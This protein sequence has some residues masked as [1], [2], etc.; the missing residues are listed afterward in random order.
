MMKQNHKVVVITGASAGIGRATALE[1]ARQ[2]ASVGLI[3][4]DRNRLEEVVHRIHEAGGTGLV[5]VGDVADAAAMNRAADRVEEELGAIDVWINCAM[6]TIFSPFE[7]MSADEFRRVTEVTYLGTVHGTKAA[8][9]HMR[10]RNHGTIVQAGSALAYRSIPLQSA[11]CGAKFAI[12]GFTDAVRVELMHERS[13][14]HVTM[15]QLAAFNTPQFQWARS[16]LDAP[17][18]PVPPIFQPELAARAL[19]FA[20]TH[21]RREWWVGF[22]AAKAIIGTRLF[23]GF[24]DRKV[25]RMAWSGQ[26]DTTADRAVTVG[27]DNLFTTVPGDFGS[28]GRFDAHSRKVSWQWLYSRHRRLVWIVFIVVVAAAVVVTRLSM[29]NGPG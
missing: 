24:T 14:V 9:K 8:L 28:H 2:G 29:A 6:V 16:R 3:S 15:V 21:R 26:M 20:A 7:E 19:V 22:P 11:Y 27:G 18:Q 10:R 17:P 5:M 23:P 4:R 12:R 13:A 25:C 1:F